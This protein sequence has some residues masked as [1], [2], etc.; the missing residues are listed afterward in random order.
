M[1]YEVYTS[2]THLLVVSKAEAE[3]LLESLQR[4][5]AGDSEGVPI[6]M[7]YFRGALTHK[8]SIVVETKPVSDTIPCA[9]PEST[10]CS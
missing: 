8:A 3:A 2:Q 5:L 6:L 4:Q 10:S 9:A 1:A 7:V